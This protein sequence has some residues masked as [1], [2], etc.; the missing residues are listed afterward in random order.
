MV[1]RRVNE[2]AA[3]SDLGG[4]YLA[5]LGHLSEEGFSNLSIY[6]NDMVPQIGVRSNGQVAVNYSSVTIGASVFGSRHRGQS[7]SWV[8]A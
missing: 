2:E 1:L 3:A 8:C 6:A 7:W 5:R 4:Q